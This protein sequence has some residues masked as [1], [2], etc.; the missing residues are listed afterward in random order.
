MAQHRIHL[1]NHVPHLPLTL[2]LR[3][4]AGTV[5]GFVLMLQALLFIAILSSLFTH[6]F[7]KSIIH[8]NRV[9]PLLAV[10]FDGLACL[11][12]VALFIV[13]RFNSL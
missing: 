13:A 3:Q 8:T 6:S 2:S 10:L 1:E 5:V 9:I 12:G 7:A 4:L 11:A